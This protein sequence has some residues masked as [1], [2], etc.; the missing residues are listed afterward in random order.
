MTPVFCIRLLS[1]R[2]T[3][4]WVWRHELPGGWRIHRVR[5]AGGPVAALEACPGY[6]G[7]QSVHGLA[8]AADRRISDARDR[9]AGPGGMVGE[10]VDGLE[11]R[12]GDDKG[13]GPAF[14]ASAAWHAASGARTFLTGGVEW[15]VRT[16]RNFREPGEWAGAAA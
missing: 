11:G 14:E 13:A 5:R 12:A 2:S 9:F 16:G 8:D 4:A 3:I 7:H 10:R 1:G 15:R 6:R